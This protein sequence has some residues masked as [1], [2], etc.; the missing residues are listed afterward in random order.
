MTP[1]LALSREEAA[2]AIGISLDSLERYVLDEIRVV[3]MGRR[4][5]VPITELDRWLDEHAERI[6]GPPRPFNPKGTR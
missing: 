6:L 5:L 4:I 3:R 2:E 1:R